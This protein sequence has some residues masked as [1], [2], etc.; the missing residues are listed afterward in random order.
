MQTYCYKDGFYGL[1]VGDEPSID[2]AENF[3][4]V[5][6]AI[7]DAAKQLGVECF[8]LLNLLPCSEPAA[9]DSFCD[10]N[11]ADIK[12]AYAEYVSA[13]IDAGKL[14]EISV[15]SYPIKPDGYGGERFLKGHYVC[16]QTL[17]EVCAAK[18]VKATLVVQSFEMVYTNGY[19]SNGWERIDNVNDMYL[20]VASALSFGIKDIAFYTYVTHADS[21]SY[22]SEDGS[23]PVT[24]NGEKTEVYNYLRSSIAQA[25]GAYGLL[26]NFTY[27]ASKLSVHSS[28]NTYSG[29]YTSTSAYSNATSSVSVSAGTFANANSFKDLVSVSNDSSIMLVTELTSKHFNA[30]AFQNV[31]TKNYA[32]KL[33][34]SQMTVT[35]QFNSYFT[36][37]LVYEFSTSSSS[38][39]WK[40]VALTNGAYEVSLPYGCCAFVIPICW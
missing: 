24:E 32:D 28:A 17:A 2:K 29:I 13:F 9:L 23:S 35:A 37:A 33:G 15:D 40:K 27:S 7:K 3:G 25:K 18:G 5:V 10:G 21:D 22:A 19:T 14:T 38:G 1:R 20:Q 4:Y 6:K 11:D 34:A 31:L 39:V 36:G 12:S 26:N 8:V 16:L 30:Y